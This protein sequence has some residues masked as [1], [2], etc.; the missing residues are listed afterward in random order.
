[1]T[2]RLYR[3]TA[4]P[5]LHI[6]KSDGQCPPWHEDVDYHH[7]TIEDALREVDNHAGD[8]EPWN[9]DETQEAYILGMG[10]TI[11]PYDEPCWVVECDSKPEHQCTGLHENY[12]T[13]ST[14][15]FAPASDADIV[16][17]SDWVLAEHEGVTYAVCENAKWTFYDEADSA[18]EAVLV[19]LGVIPK[20]T[21]EGDALTTEESA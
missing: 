21:E 10:L 6:L 13:G 16:K 9:E 2:V 15:H 20:P 3:P 5:C 14:I 12:D 11:A 8:Y 17:D 19:H 7:P 1:V 18:E 4:E